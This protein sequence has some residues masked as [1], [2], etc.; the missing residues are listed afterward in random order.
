MFPLVVSLGTG[1][2][3]LKNN[4]PSMSGPHN[5]WKDGAFPRLCHMYWEKIRDR[6]VGQIFQTHPRYHIEFDSPEP[7]LDDTNSM[8]DLKS[9]A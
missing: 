6:K 9:K 1:A 2:P 5:I 8:P 7:R 4:G 3:R